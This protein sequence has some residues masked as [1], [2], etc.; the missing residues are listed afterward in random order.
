MILLDTNLL[1]RLARKSHPHGAI[2]RVAV[3]KL[4][5]R[6]EKIV[7]V[8]QNLYEFWAV[9]TRPVGVSPVGQN[10]LG[11]TINQAN[12]WL[13]LFQRRFSLLPDREDLLSRWHDLVKTLG[14]RGFR[15]HDARFV[16]AMECYGIT[17]LLTFNGKDFEAF[18]VTIIDPSKV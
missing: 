1:T 9:A 12:Q 13:R 16:A 14:I 3:T 10:G 5:G 4:L 8:P 11:M 18:A 17:Q 6:G 15:A 7:I 2:A